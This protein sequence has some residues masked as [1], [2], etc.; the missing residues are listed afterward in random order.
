MNNRVIAARILILLCLAVLIEVLV[1]VTF[2]LWWAL[3]AMIA[4]SFSFAA[5]VR[6][7]EAEAG[8]WVERLSMTTRIFSASAK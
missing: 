8:L 7:I 1:G 3:L 4:L 2:G 6:L 5:S